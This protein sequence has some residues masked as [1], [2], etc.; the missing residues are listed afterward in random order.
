MTHEPIKAV[1]LRPWSEDDLSLLT[2]LLGDPEMM[3]HLGGPETPEQIAA[4]HGRY[5]AMR[6]QGRGEMLVIALAGL[7]VGSKYTAFIF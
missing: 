2:R 5:L 6:G 4:R 1:H 3:T 7:A